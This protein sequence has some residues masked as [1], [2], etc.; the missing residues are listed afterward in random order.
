MKPEAQASERAGDD[1]TVFKTEGWAQMIFK[2]DNA[3]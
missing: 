3:G 1:Q 2:I